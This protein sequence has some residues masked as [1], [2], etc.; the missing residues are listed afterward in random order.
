MSFGL[1]QGVATLSGGKGVMRMGSV[2]WKILEFDRELVMGWRPR[3]MGLISARCRSSAW[4]TIGGKKD[5]GK[6]GWAHHIQS[7]REE[8]LIDH[9]RI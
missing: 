4:S 1:S 2:E 9:I 3:L 5:G 8:V 7:R 6:P